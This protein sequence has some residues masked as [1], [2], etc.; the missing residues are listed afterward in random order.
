[1]TLMA[2]VEKKT[3][4]SIMFFPKLLMD[5]FMLRKPPRGL[6]LINRFKNA[7]FELSKYQLSDLV[8]FT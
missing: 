5:Y 4:Q 8:Y 2:E 1:M 7:F 3:R 6:K